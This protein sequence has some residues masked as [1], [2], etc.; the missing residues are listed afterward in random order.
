[1]ITELGVA[2]NTPAALD[3]PRVLRHVPRATCHVADVAT[4]RAG[5]LFMQRLNLSSC[6][7]HHSWLNSFIND[8]LS[9]LINLVER[10]E[11]LPRLQQAHD[12]KT[13]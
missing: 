12:I 11:S 6:F 3:P 1:M 8:F 2:R 13:E 4:C 10:K 9:G 7:V 5:G